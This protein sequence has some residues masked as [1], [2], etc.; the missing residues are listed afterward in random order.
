M[1]EKELKFK[2]DKKPIKLRQ[3]WSRLWSL[4]V[5]SRQQIIYVLVLVVAYEIFK[6]VGPY[7][8][9]R[10]IYLITSFKPEYINDI[11]IFIALILVF[12]LV[13]ALI[14]YFADKAIFKILTEVEKYL[15]VNAQTK[16]V[17]LGLSYHEREN[18]GNKIF[19]IQRGIDKIIDLLGNSFW[20][21][22]PTIVQ[23]ILT[24]LIM[25]F[26]DW[27]FGLIFAL[28]VPL[29]AWLTAKLN[30]EIAPLRKYRHDQYEAAAG[31]MAQTIININTVKSFVQE[32]REIKEFG[33]IKQATKQVALGVA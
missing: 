11:L 22:G 3:F 7:L 17:R 33:K 1:A 6:F 23:V 31:K 26:V 28:F 12:D 16:M 10:I 14:D 21:V 19:K 2:L 25:F 18:T 27:R 8:L 13:V 30:L 4:I 32:D 9:K 15:S 5:P 20:E 24:A 29:F